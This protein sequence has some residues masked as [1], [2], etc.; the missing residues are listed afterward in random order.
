MELGLRGKVALV[1][2][3][4]RGIGAAIAMELAREGVHVC[5]VAR[6]LAKL[7]EVAAA[8]RGNANV[9][10]SVHVADLRVPEGA[11]A[12][13]KAATDEFGQLDILVNNA[14]ATKR[15]DFFTLTEEDWQDGFALKFHGYVRM[16]RAAWPHLKKVKGSVVNIVGIGSR[17]GSAEFTI[18][19][20]VNVA[21][22]N[23]TKAM[24]DIGVKDGV[25][26]NAINPGL[27]ETDRFTRNIERTMRD[28]SLGRDEAMNFLLSSHGTTRVG[29]PEEIGALTAFLASEQAGFIQ[30]S[31]IDIDGGA[32]RSL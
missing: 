6:D 12:A 7:N 28:R 3:A 21:I 15:A 29:R 16:T 17:A 24:A 31:I 20:S 1:T 8:V 5:L 13:V 10:T 32:T 25:R 9:R 11:A 19:G 27:I 23:F 14:G 22:L 2:G 30:G 26:V 4:S 18:G